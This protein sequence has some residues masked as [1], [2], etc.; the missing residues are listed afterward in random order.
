[1]APPTERQGGF[2]LIEAL[3]ALAILAMVT[4]G[5]LG[6]RTSAIIDAN[7]A[8]HWQIAREIAQ[9]MLSELRAGAREYRP[10]PGRVPIEKYKG[11]SSQILIG[12]EMISQFEAEEANWDIGGGERGQRLTWQSE[13]DDQRRARQKGLSL[14]DYRDERFKEQNQLDENETPSEDELED[15]LVI[16]YFPNVRITDESSGPEAS[17]KLKAKLSTLAIEGLTPDEADALDGS[18]SSA[19]PVTGDSG[20]QG[21]GT[22]GSR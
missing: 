21:D 10:E 15:V 17:F 5:F 22:G 9:Q 14:Q 11:F 7:E 8:H 3:V 1:M 16:V 12:E 18:S 2:T 4:V 6:M 13:R 20:N 19:T